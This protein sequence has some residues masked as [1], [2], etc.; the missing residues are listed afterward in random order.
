RISSGREPYAA[1]KPAPTLLVDAVARAGARAALRA[2]DRLD[3][4]VEGGRAA[5]LATLL[6]LTGASDAAELLAAPSARRPDYVG[7]D[8]GALT[9]SAED[10]AP[11]PRPGWD[12]RVSDTGE[13]TLSATGGDA[14]PLDALRALCAVHWAAGGG[15]AQLVVAGPEATRAV[16]A[17]GLDGTGSGSVTV[18]AA[19]T[20]TRGDSGARIDT[21]GAQR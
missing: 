13:L 10:L 8:L 11:G 19:D 16:R 21:A 9:L 7:A 4:D 3:T 1:D 2:G 17:L 12:A 15:A 14:D 20:T 5:G 18:A 6:V